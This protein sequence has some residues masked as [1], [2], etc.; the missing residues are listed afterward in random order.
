MVCFLLCTVHRTD[1]VFNKHT[2]GQTVCVGSLHPNRVVSFIVF[3][4]LFIMSYS[5]DTLYQQWVNDH[6]TPKTPLS[7]LTRESF[8][9][10]MLGEY[11]CLMDE[12][13]PVDD[14]LLWII[15]NIPEDL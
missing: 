3:L 13:L 5:F 15:N 10:N 6:T 4:L 8:I 2:S 7:S 11:D 14:D 12:G 9:Q 1:V